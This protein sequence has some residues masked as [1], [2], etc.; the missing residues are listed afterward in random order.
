MLGHCRRICT[1]RELA[2]LTESN[3]CACA[4]HPR[5]RRLAR[6]RSS[7]RPRRTDTAP[8]APRSY[9]PPAAVRHAVS[10]RSP[11]M[12]AHPRRTKCSAR[13]KGGLACSSPDS[14]QCLATAATASA[15]TRTCVACFSMNRAL[16]RTHHNG[17]HSWS[18][19]PAAGS[20]SAAMLPRAEVAMFERDVI[21]CQG[22]AGLTDKGV[23][24]ASSATSPRRLRCLLPSLFHR[25]P[26]ELVTPGAF[27][28]HNNTTAAAAAPVRLCLCHRLPDAFA[29]SQR[30][31]VRTAADLASCAA[32]AVGWA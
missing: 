20:S 29:T 31:Y 1:R 24:P 10:P 9:R 12:S 19:V 8:S 27:G 7:A 26:M 22:A 6:S 28:Q 14:C 16:S 23:P 25:T 5:S 13:S 15:S 17:Q 21:G 3:V 11:V 2:G 18:A 4:A 30:A 32:C